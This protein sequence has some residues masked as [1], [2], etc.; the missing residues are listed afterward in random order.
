[1]SKKLIF[2]DLKTGFKWEHNNQDW[3]LNFCNFNSSIHPSL[4]RIGQTINI[5]D[6]NGDPVRISCVKEVE[7]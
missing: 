6:A 5:K 2:E 7:Q 4:L 3:I 1:M